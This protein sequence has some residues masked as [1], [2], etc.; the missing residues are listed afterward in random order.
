MPM[1]MFS[2]EPSNGLRMPP[3]RLPTGFNTGASS[4]VT[5]LS[6]PPSSGVEVVGGSSP[7]SSTTT[8]TP[9]LGGLLSPVTSLLAPVLPPVG[10]LLGGILNP[11]LGSVLNINI[12]ISGGG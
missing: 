1:L 2:T 5:G 11:L 6:R 7:T 3:S 9:L 4:E 8:S 12:G 10:S